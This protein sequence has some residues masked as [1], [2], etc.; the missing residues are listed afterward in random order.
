MNDLARKNISVLLV[1][2]DEDDYIIIKRIFSKIP[3]SPFVLR[4]CSDFGI[5]KELVKS[6]E[7]D[8]FLIDYRLGVHT[9]LELLEIAEAKRRSEPFILLTGAGDAKIENKAI[10]LAAAD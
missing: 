9:G 7:F 3:D 6:Q 8:I 1:D 2:D 4:W 5:A 10:Q